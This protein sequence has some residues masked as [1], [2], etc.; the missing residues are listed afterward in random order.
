MGQL[1][2]L[3]AVALVAAAL[4]WGV[5]VLITGGDPGLEPAEP[6]GRANPLPNVRPL[7]EADLGA[8]RFDT[9]VRGY[10]MAQVDQAIR[11]AAY[12]IGYK[13]ELINVLEAE[14]SALRE[15]RTED[16]EVLRKAREAAQRPRTPEM[17]PVA[18]DEPDGQI[19]LDAA[20]AEPFAEAEPEAAPAAEASDPVDVAEP[21]DTVDADADAALAVPADAEK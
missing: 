16:A 15:G 19:V 10:R 3:L 5:A 21:D 11:R 20:A 9:T 2:I 17:A 1:L 6:D 7:H 12:D 13:A 4:V 14:V 18:Q 8:V